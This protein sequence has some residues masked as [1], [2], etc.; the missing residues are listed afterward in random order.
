MANNCNNYITIKGDEIEL[1]DFYELLKINPDEND[2]FDIYRNIV[3]EFAPNKEDAKWFEIDM[4]E[5]NRTEIILSGDSAWCPCLGVFTK[6]SKKYPSFI[7]HYQYDESGCDFAG[8]ADISKGDCDDNCF[9]FWKGKIINFGEQEA[10]EDVISNELS[11]YESEEELIDSDMYKAFN[12]VSKGKIL[13]EYIE[14]IL[15][16]V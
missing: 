12:A 8:Y 2:G 4:H 7:I 9:T 13:K 11:C 1:K 16:K 15:D 6:I 3:S 14:F 5:F 10:L